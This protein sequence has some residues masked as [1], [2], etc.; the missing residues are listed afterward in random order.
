MSISLPHPPLVYTQAHDHQQEIDLLSRWL[1]NKES[2]LGQNIP[3]GG[4]PE[5]ASQQLAEHMVG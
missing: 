5:T 2:E 1:L 4:L 3:Y